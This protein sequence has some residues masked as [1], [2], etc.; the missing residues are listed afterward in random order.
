M[1]LWGLGGLVSL[2]GL[3]RGVAWE[4]MIVCPWMGA[5]GTATSLR[6]KRP[7]GQEQRVIQP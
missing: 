5:E 6:Q 1:I 7:V 3:S 4:L 2:P